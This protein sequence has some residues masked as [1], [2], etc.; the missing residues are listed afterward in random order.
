MLNNIGAGL[1]QVVVYRGL[2][3]INDGTDTFAL[4]FALFGVGTFIGVSLNKLL[5]SRL[6]AQ[7]AIAIAAVIGAVSTIFALIGT[8]VD[9]S[10]ALYA[11]E[12][13]A[14]VASA[15]IYP[16]LQSIIKGLS[17]GSARWAKKAARLDLLAYSGQVLF[18]TLLGTLLAP[19]VSP[20]VYFGI[21]M[22]TSLMALLFLFFTK[23]NS[24]SGQS[25]QDLQKQAASLSLLSS[26]KRRR[27]I[28]YLP[29]LALLTSG[30]ISS[31]PSLSNGIIL[32]GTLL[33]VADVASWALAFRGCGQVAASLV[34]SNR[35]VAIA[36]HYPRVIG[37]AFV[38]IYFLACKT[39][40]FALFGCLVIFAHYLSN[41]MF[42]SGYSALQNAF[43]KAEV[44]AASRFELQLF[45]LALVIGALGFPYLVSATN[46]AISLGIVAAAFS[47]CVFCWEG[48]GWKRQLVTKHIGES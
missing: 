6:D 9:S 13:L 11:A 26:V 46:L 37:C 12:L 14:A 35:I 4:I 18:G 23:L 28:F 5:M 10:G 25:N 29:A 3:S 21:D 15:V 22:I 20:G 32:N 33:K 19:L 27:G 17:D 2:A 7:I 38:S 40:N 42:I 39:E 47:L 45:T 48:F 43:S 24:T 8:K 34:P 44:D 30:V 36:D 16:S 1:T 41:H 31:F